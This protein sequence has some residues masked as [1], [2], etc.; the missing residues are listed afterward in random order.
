[1]T[2]RK[3]T[4]EVLAGLNSQLEGIEIFCTSS[5]QKEI[6]WMIAISARN[7][8]QFGASRPESNRGLEWEPRGIVVYTELQTPDLIDCNSEDSNVIR[9]FFVTFVKHGSPCFVFNPIRRDILT[10]RKHDTND[11]IVGD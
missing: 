2:A 6:K 11:I 4:V 7:E 10:R 1:M 9:T 3:K 8:I 5:A